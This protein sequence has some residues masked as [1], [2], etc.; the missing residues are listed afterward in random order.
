MIDLHC[1]STAS[2]GTCSPRELVSMAVKLGLKALALTDHDTMDGLPEF[3]AAAREFPQT[4][5]VSGVELAARSRED[6]RL[7]YHI[8]GL[9]LGEPSREM[10]EFMAGC[11][12]A[13]VERNRA[14]LE[15]LAALGHPL[16][17]ADLEREADGGV[18]GRP[19]I[20][21]ALVRRGVVES[22]QGAFQRFLGTG[23]PAYVSRAVPSPGEAISAIHSCGGVAVWAHPFTKGNHTVRK[24]H[25][26]A[27]DLKAVGLDGMECY[28]AL[29]TP[30]QVQNALEICRDVGLFPSGGSDFHGE[31]I[32]GVKLGVGTGRLQ[33]PD[34]LLEPLRL[35]AAHRAVVHQA[36]PENPSADPAEYPTHQTAC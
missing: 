33:V 20:A 29:H 4:C 23:K 17:M 3:Q 10:K 34:R 11:R 15:R 26:M 25:Q 14:I 30:R 35:C 2:D 27:V 9:F 28:Y 1:H 13:R 12:K 16:E 8:V 5:C 32:H 22:V 6:Y 31:N 36:P 24:I 21:R 7:G 18:Q 19:H